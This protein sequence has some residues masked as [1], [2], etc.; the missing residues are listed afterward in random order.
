MNSNTHDVLHEN[1]T[2]SARCPVFPD[3]TD[4]RGCGFSYDPSLFDSGCLR[5]Y[6][7][8]ERTKLQKEAVERHR[9]ESYR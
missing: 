5:D 6:P 3:R 7:E 1:R 9:K 8:A 4:C 2:G